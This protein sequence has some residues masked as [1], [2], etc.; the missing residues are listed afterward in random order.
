VARA[1]ITISSTEIGTISADPDRVVSA[2]GALNPTLVVPLQVDLDRHTD[3]EP[4]LAVSWLEARLRLPGGPQGSS[5]SI[6][7]VSFRFTGAL[8]H[9]TIHSL[10]FISRHE[11]PIDFALTTAQ[12]RALEDIAHDGSGDAVPITL[13]FSGLVCQVAGGGPVSLRHGRNPVAS[14]HQVGNVYD[15]RPIAETGQ[16]RS[17]LGGERGDRRSVV[18]A[19]VV[20]L[21]DDE[22]V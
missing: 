22:P 14:R 20:L 16:G 19:D 15:L 3:D 6:G 4:V 9:A 13:S 2:G 12:V 10:P 1:S 7:P 5:P 17:S 18:H 8:G 11:L 21:A